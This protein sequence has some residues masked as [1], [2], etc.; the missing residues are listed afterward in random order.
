[1]PS[2]PCQINRVRADHNT[3]SLD[4]CVPASARSAA[5]AVTGNFTAWVPVL[6]NATADGGFSMRVVIPRGAQLRY[7]VLLDG[8]PDEH[9][10]LAR[11]SA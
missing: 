10:P 11:V 9:R 5:P 1:M 4:L 7:R 3:V 2:A 6:M 8:L